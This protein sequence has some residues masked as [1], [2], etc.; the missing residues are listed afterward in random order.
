MEAGAIAATSAKDIQKA[1]AKRLAHRELTDEA[2]VAVSKRI[3]RDGL[4]IGGVDFCP[5]GICID[6]FSDRRILVD[7]IMVGEKYRAVRLFPYGIL[8]DD[9]WRLQVEM[10]VPEL[11]GMGGR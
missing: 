9:L 11:A 8:V 2:I 3:V 1:L 4:K 5:Y 7:K 6:Y 10:Q